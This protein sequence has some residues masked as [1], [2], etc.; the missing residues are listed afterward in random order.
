MISRYWQNKGKTEADKKHG[1][2]W[3]AADGSYRCAEC[4]NKDR[5]SDCDHY[6]RPNC[7]YCLGTGVN[8][9]TV[10]DLFKFSNND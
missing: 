10:D 7:P 5:E 9:T 1:K 2:T 3:I 8:A 6:Y 4:C